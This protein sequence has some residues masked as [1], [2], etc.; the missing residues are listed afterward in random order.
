M[1]VYILALFYRIMQTHYIRLH[2]YMYIQTRSCTR[3]TQKKHQMFCIWQQGSMRLS[4]MQSKL[5]RRPTPKWSHYTTL[6]C[7]YWVVMTAS[8]V[9]RHSRAT[10]KQ[11]NY[12]TIHK[13]RY[14]AQYKI[15]ERKRR[16]WSWKGGT[17][18][19]VFMH[20]CINTCTFTSP[21]SS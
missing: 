10:W 16:K 12:M 1:S 18:I 4:I 3:Y 8:G 14:D 9:Y 19:H 7:V 5:R 15:V 21:M 17:T 2:T 6:S 11:Q 13:I 20:I